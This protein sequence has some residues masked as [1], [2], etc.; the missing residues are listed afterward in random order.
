MCTF[1]YIHTHKYIQM[2]KKKTPTISKKQLFELRIHPCPGNQRCADQVFAHLLE[3][4]HCA[5][6][7]LCGH[8]TLALKHSK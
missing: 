1:T 8:Y 2:I 4:L 7:L 5:S 6:Q 3:S